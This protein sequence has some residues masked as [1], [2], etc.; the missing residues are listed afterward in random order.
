MDGS[1][2]SNLHPVK[3]LS[4]YP[5]PHA[6]F[7]SH[8]LIYCSASLDQQYLEVAKCP[9]LVW[10]TAGTWCVACVTRTLTRRT[11]LHTCCPAS[12]TCA[13][14]AGLPSRPQAPSTAPRVAAPSQCPV[15]F[16]WTGLGWCCWTRSSAPSLEEEE[17]CVEGESGHFP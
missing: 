2:H 5:S 7:T 12:M 9:K 3:H 16:Q 13:R 14:P 17:S 8:D 1:R 10:W 6:F 15:P 4:I 11:T